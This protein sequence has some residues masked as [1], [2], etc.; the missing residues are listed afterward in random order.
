M[1]DN[2]ELPVGIGGDIIATDELKQSDGT[3]VK[4]QRVKVQHGED[5]KATD[6][7]VV[8]PIPVRD[9]S[10]QETL[11]AILIEAR[12]IRRHLEEWSEQVFTEADL[13]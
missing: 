10:M 7:S 12:I 5:G 11:S 3:F 2:T 8:D 4:H 1:A 9:M 13:E 6:T